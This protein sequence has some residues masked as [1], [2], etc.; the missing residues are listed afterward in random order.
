MSIIYCIPGTGVDS[1]LFSKLDLPG[2]ELRHIVWIL[3]HKREKLKDYALRLSEQIDTSIPFVLIGVSFGGMICAE[4]ARVLSPQR[5]FLI[6]S[7]KHRGELPLKLR[8]LKAIPFY[9][10][11]HDRAYVFSA[12]LSRRIFGY[13]GS[14]DGKL[15]REMLHTAPQG[16]FRRAA[17]CI[18]GWDARSSEPGI[19]HIHGTRDRVLPLRNI[20]ADY[21]I[22][23]GSHNLLHD[24]AAEISQIIQ[25]ELQKNRNS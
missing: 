4:L 3:P 20:K 23:G 19:V 8:F 12:T 6:A 9:R 22:Q 18:V 21:I 7:S 13:K 2:H 11:M 16:Y 24:H 17:D 5:V 1:R 10:I 15:F 14:A 25:K